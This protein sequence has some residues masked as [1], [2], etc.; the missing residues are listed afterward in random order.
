[1]ID[2]RG[3]GRR[4]EP[5]IKIF[6]DVASQ[7]LSNPLLKFNAKGHYMNAGLCHLAAGVRSTHACAALL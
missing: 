7:C 6:E 5:A 4:Y 1:M 2:P 3:W